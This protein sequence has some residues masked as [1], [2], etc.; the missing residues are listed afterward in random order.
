[1]KREFWQTLAPI[2]IVLLM[3][4]IGLVVSYLM[5]TD[6]EWLPPLREK[7]LLIVAGFFG[8]GIVIIIIGLIAEWRSDIE[9]S[10]GRIGGLG[11]LL[12]FF[13]GLG[14]IFVGLFLTP[15]GWGLLA[16]VALVRLIGSF[17]QAKKLAAG[18]NSV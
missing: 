15:I 18:T 3:I 2:L 7:A 16:L 4:V 17:R 9:K 10:R 12:I 11:S 14:A 13:A 6:L 5:L 1:M 8:L